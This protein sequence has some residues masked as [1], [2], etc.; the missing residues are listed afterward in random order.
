MSKKKKSKINVNLISAQTY[1]E[2]EPKDFNLKIK[3]TNAE[4]NRKSLEKVKDNNSII[5]N[6]E[7]KNFTCDE[8]FIKNAVD[9]IFNK[10]KIEEKNKEKEQFEKNG[11]NLYDSYRKVKTDL[12]F[13]SSY[14]YEINK[15]KYY[16]IKGINFSLHL[17]TRAV[18]K[19][20]YFE[21]VDFSKTY[22][23]NSYIRD[24]RFVRCNFEGAKFTNS[25]LQ[26]SYFENCNFDFVIFEKTFVD[27]EIFECA[28]ERNNL[29]YKFAR[30]LK[31]NYASIG[32]YIKASKA[33]KIEL[34]AT[35]K[36]LYDT[37]TLNDD[38][39]R[40]KY[41]GIRKRITQFWKWFKVTLLDF[42]WGNGE[43]LWRLIRLNL[44]LF[45]I[46]TVYDFFHNKI[47]KA[48]DILNIF[49]IKVPSNYFGL[50]VVETK[51]LETIDYFSYYPPILSLFL[52]I[53]RLICFGLLMSIII[54]KYN[55]R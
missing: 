19:D 52:N 41:G 53:T 20:I 38:Y 30:S 18:A 1:N 44:F 15:H 5:C 54:K 43:S 46:L 27:D 42:I 28:P 36:H 39:H 14:S 2:E 49:A 34:E 16:K 9:A 8:E 12:M 26:G 17:F 50:K 4:I 48:I 35:K 23:D 31:L 29:K 51:G 10:K 45:G 32:D 33:V 21:N 55:R 6:R 25:N 11:S 7:L 13:Y 3:K 22:F 37:W 40:N 24:C 47:N